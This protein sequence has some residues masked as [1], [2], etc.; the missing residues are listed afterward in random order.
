MKTRRQQGRGSL[1]L[2]HP[3]S[4]YSVCWHVKLAPVGQRNEH[5][6]RDVF[7]QPSHFT[8]MCRVVWPTPI[9]ALGF[10]IKSTLGQH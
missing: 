7:Y 1:A 4:V 10:F 6:A 3:V 5:G 8:D 9:S 2:I